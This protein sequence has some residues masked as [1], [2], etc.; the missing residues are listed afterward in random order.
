MFHDYLQR[1]SA[2]DVRRA[3]IDLFNVLDTK[4]EDRDPYMDEDL[5]AFPYVNGGLLRTR[6]SS[7]PG[8]MQKSLT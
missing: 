2:R 4:P 7:F 8:W 5:A 1:Y 6:T 3:L